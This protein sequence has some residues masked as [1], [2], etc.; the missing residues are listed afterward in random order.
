MICREYAQVGIQQ[1][2]AQTRL[3]TTFFLHIVDRGR[4]VSDDHGIELA[5]LDAARA[6]AVRVISELLDSGAWTPARH[7]ANYIDITDEHGRVL[8]TVAVWEVLLRNPKG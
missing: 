2:D 8:D 4:S 6:E 3:M 7:S 5:D 1:A